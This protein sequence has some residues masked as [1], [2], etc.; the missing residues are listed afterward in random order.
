MILKATVGIF[1]TMNPGYAGRS[2]LPD[3]LKALFRPVTMV[4]PDL[5][6][7]CENML[8]SEG[9]NLAKIL[10]K[11]MTVL[12][13]LAKEQ[14]SK[15]YHYDFGLRA[16]KSVLVMAGML[17]R[18]YADLD[19]DI[20]LMRA[21]RDMNMPK[22]IFED[23]PLFTGLINDLFPGL[24]AE[25]VGYE[26]LKIKIIEEME[27]KG[28]RHQ[29]E[30][31][32]YDQVNKVLQ[33][34]ETMNTRHTT[35]VVGPTGSGKSVILSTLA[36]SLKEYTGIPTKR[37]VINPKM[38]TLNE[39]YGVLDPASRDWTDGLLSKT[40]KEMNQEQPPDK[41]ETRWIVYDGDVDAVWVENMNSVM[42]DN[43]LLTLSNGDR[44]RLQ[45]WSAMLFEVY[46]LQY[47]SPATISRCGMVYVD[48]KNLGYYPY[49]ERWCTIQ[50]A[51]FG[52]AVYEAFKDLYQRYIPP[53]INRILD[54]ALG[55]DIVEPLRFVTPQ[56]N[57]NM[58]RQFCLLM[59][60]M[61]PEDPDSNTKTETEDWEKL[62]IFCA[63]WGLGGALV[64]EDREKFNDFFKSN[65]GIIFSGPE[66]IYDNCYDE[67]T[68]QYNP[69]KPKVPPYEPPASKKFSAILVPTV[70]TL[71][72][73]WLLSQV[74]KMNKPCMFVGDSGT[75]KT[76]TINSYLNT[77]PMEKYIILNVNF[78]S[79][80][81]SKDCQKSIEDNIDKR[82]MR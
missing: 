39:L 45:K 61:L 47:A 36:A 25:R 37:D 48:P 40:F 2:E 66:T 65:S 18:A 7:I 67:N 12:Y 15:Q 51:K 28:L 29:D 60:S 55:E 81:T 52:E 1:I 24:T 53:A 20:V 50:K 8:M 69:W 78:S 4:V 33:L 9:F 5:I 57:L 26:D 59:D 13:K 63:I 58:V 32:F 22:F 3:N 64:S 14:L 62:F 17:K 56:T 75:A 19:E 68:G 80:T 49:Y 21:L 38:V 74:M 27:N 73:S 6:L 11:K 71:R 41:P 77:L 82:S 31:I 46:D 76:V 44:I 16:L 43:R 23:V 42:D 79:R 30:E 70:D 35:M 72:Y 54:G 10:A 34:Y